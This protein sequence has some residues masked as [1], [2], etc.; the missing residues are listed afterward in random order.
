MYKS[1]Q[2]QFVNKIAK[3]ESGYLAGQYK[4]LFNWSFVV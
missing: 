3:N 2:L 4:Y 1:I